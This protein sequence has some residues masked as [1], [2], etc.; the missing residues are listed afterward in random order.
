MDPVKRD[1][2]NSIAS[3]KVAFINEAPPIIRDAEV[4]YRVAQPL[5][6]YEQRVQYLKANADKL[7]P[8]VV[9]QARTLNDSVN[10]K[11]A[12]NQYFIDTIASPVVRPVET[13]ALVV[14]PS[15]QEVL[16]PPVFSQNN[17][18]TNDNLIV[19]QAQELANAGE[20]PSSTGTAQSVLEGIAPVSSAL[21]AIS[22]PQA[23]ILPEPQPLTVPRGV[24]TPGQPIPDDVMSVVNPSL[25]RYRDNVQVVPA[26]DQ[27]GLGIPIPLPL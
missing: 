15:V 17:F 10:Y 12:L 16:Q 27:L 14:A 7:D 5:D 26:Q 23:L 1:Y 13:E 24:W 6:T 11:K 2:L 9:A 20:N 25:Q 4:G 8:A 21:T 18:V 3:N 22:E 19:T